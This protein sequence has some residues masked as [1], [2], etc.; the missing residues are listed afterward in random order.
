MGSER[1]QTSR[2]NPGLTRKDILIWLIM[3]LAELILFT[4]DNSHEGVWLDETIAFFRSG[5]PLKEI[6][7]LCGR[8]I[9][10]PLYFIGLWAVRKLLGSS[11]FIL[12][13][14]SALGAAALAALGMGPVRRLFGR[15]TG[16]IFTLLIIATPA[17]FEMSREMRNYTW[18]AF[19]TAG[20]ALYFILAIN[21]NRLRD[22]TLA[23]LFGI[24]CAYTHYNGLIAVLIL[25]IF[26]FVFLCLKKR[27]ILPPFIIVN[28]IIALFFLPWLVYNFNIPKPP[29]D[30]GALTPWLVR[31]AILFPFGFKFGHPPALT[32]FPVLILSLLVTFTGFVCGS[33]VK[34][35]N[36]IFGI[37][38]FSAYWLT[39]AIIMVIMFIFNISAYPRHNF[40][41]IGLFILPLARG[42]SIL[43][44]PELLP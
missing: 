6:L 26:L 44:I 13:G 37:I 5:H 34:G 18:S 1:E 25:N 3:I 11:V 12:R 15:K 42:F 29:Q 27:E 17:V 14:F 4:A 21:N 32:A 23:G 31:Q 2:Y 24:A 9:H 10:P 30:N 41:S 40:P 7:N 43:K 35:Q 39:L 20:T 36:N 19:F 22:W 38:L 33:R 8:D 28:I 16:L